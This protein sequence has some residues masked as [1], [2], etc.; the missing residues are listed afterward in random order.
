M[1]SE[2]SWQS[3]FS[4]PW[5]IPVLDVGPCELE[6]VSCRD[7]ISLSRPKF[8]LAASASIKKLSTSQT[9]HLP[10]ATFFPSLIFL[11]F[12]VFS[13]L[14]LCLCLSLWFDFFFLFFSEAK[15][16]AGEDVGMV[17]VQRRSLN[18]STH[19]RRQTHPPCPSGSECCPSPQVLR[20]SLTHP[21]GTRFVFPAY[22]RW[23]PPTLTQYLSD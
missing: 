14:S 1:C 22:N 16:E 4:D 23:V 20:C 5:G 19:L 21:L 12:I 9:V 8:S 11:T 2:S 13:L 18:L 6:V 17:V 7:V 10:H 3:H 15:Q